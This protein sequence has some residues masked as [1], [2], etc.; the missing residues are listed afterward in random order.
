MIASFS[1]LPPERCEVRFVLDLLT[2]A[3]GAGVP[4]GLEL[5]IELKSKGREPPAGV[6]CVVRH[7][8]LLPSSEM[9]SP[10]YEV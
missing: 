2:H 3:P 4:S 9:K 5:A 6:G 10:W 7:A 8:S 1:F